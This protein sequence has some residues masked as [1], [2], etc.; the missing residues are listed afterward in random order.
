MALSPETGSLEGVWGA[1]SLGSGSIGKVDA[2][3]NETAGD[4]RDSEAGAFSG[5]RG[6][7]REAG[8]PGAA[9]AA[10][11]PL[12]HLLFSTEMQDFLRGPICRWASTL[13][14]KKAG[15]SLLVKSPE[16]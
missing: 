8:I 5:A 2:S 7:R 14:R 1:S 16:K 3:T 12:H 4:V 15:F 10:P 9:T 11:G 6:G 13:S